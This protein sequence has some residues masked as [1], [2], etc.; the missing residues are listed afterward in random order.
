MAAPIQGDTEIIKLDLPKTAKLNTAV[1]GTVTVVIPAGWHAYQNPPMDKY[2]TPVTV[3][4]KDKNVVLKAAKYPKGM[5]IDS[6]DG[7]AAVYEG[8]IKI[9]ISVVF[10]KAGK[11]T[12]TLNVL[13]QQ[14]DDKSCMPPKFVKPTAVVVVK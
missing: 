1:S 13:Y 6:F 9:P 3:S 4:S 5:I 11:Q 8:T 14:C 10:K 2:Q 7:Q 12:V